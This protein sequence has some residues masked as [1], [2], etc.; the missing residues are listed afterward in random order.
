MEFIM[1]Q[2]D[3]LNQVRRICDFYEKDL[4][5]INKAAEICAEAIKNKN[6]L[7]FFKVGHDNESDFLNRAGG[8]ASAKRFSF[9][10]GWSADVPECRTEGLGKDKPGMNL[11]AVKLAL[12]ASN[13]R[14]GD[15]MFVGSVSGKTNNYVDLA[16]ACKELGITTIG[17]TSL[18]YTGQVEATHP[19][20]KKLLDVVDIVI[21]NGAPFGDACVDCVGLDHK[22]L[23]ISGVSMLV[24]GWLIMGKAAEILGEQGMAP[25]M[26]ESVNKP[27]GF[28][29][30]DNYVKTFN[31]R[32]F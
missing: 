13:I 26:F 23:P 20:G 9:N 17:F 25:T 12:K 4:S 18:E 31:E 24:A 29:K 28:E 21:D 7:Y 30:Y 1:I 22:V 3:Y 14:K 6:L 5:Q 32:G 2:L 27:N 19:S 8:L 11:E 16:L 10:F 15:I